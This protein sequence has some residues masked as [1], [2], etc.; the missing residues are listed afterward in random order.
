VKYPWTNGKV[1]RVIKT[2]MEMW[3]SKTE[4]KSKK[5]CKLELI[6]FVNYY[7]TIKTHKG[8]DGNTPMEKLIDYFFSEEL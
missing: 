1:E 2:L 8:I 5:H 4:F 6:R 7:N 3:H